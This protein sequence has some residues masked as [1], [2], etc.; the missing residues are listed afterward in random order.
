MAQASQHKMDLA[1]YPSILFDNNSNAPTIH[2]KIMVMAHHIRKY[3]TKKNVF[4]KSNELLQKIIKIKSYDEKEPEIPRKNPILHFSK[5][6]YARLLKENKKNK[7]RRVRVPF[8]RDED[9]DNIFSNT[10]FGDDLF[11]KDK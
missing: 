5:T 4:N 9:R 8:D 10:F 1:I 11:N 6:K 2:L 7:D 3:E